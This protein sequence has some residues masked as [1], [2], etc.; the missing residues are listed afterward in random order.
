MTEQRSKRA[1]TALND[2]SSLPEP[3]DV[4]EL[5]SQI[6]IPPAND[7]RLWKVISSALRCPNCG[8]PDHKAETG[9]RINSDGLQEQYRHCENCNIRFRAV[10]E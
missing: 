9:K 1:D 8:S 2:L 4:S 7:R 6:N 10:F 3:A 5:E